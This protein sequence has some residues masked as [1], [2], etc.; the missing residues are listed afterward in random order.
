MVQ[1]ISIDPDIIDKNILENSLLKIDQGFQNLIEVKKM[2]N[3][4]I[5]LNNQIKE[6][7]IKNITQLKIYLNN[8]IEQNEEY[9]KLS[10]NSLRVENLMIQLLNSPEY[11]YKFKDQNFDNLKFKDY[12]KKLYNK[13]GPTFLDYVLVGKILKTGFLEID[14]YLSKYLE[15]RKNSNREFYFSKDIVNFKDFSKKIIDKLGLNEFEKNQKIYLINPGILRTINNKEKNFRKF[16]DLCVTI[17]CICY[18]FLDKFKNSKNLPSVIVATDNPGNKLDE[19]NLRNIFL[20]EFDDLRE[21]INL[22]LIVIGNWGKKSKHEQRFI[23]SSNEFGYASNVDLDFL[24]KSMHGNHLDA[25]KSIKNNYSQFKVAKHGILSEISQSAY[26][27]FVYDDLIQK[28]DNKLN[29]MIYSLNDE[30]ALKNQ[31]FLDVLKN[32][33]K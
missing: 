6:Q 27:N 19:N 11:I 8:N 7:I 30:N 14:D 32:F 22:N 16:L 10:N 24:I 2:E 4:S 15:E 33:N 20:T 5:F 12:I 25:Y 17:K 28:I 31:P 23:F 29:T 1:K 26:K 13:F 3:P 9:R 18:Y 21:N